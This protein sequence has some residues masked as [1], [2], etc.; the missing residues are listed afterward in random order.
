MFELNEKQ[1]VVIIRAGEK[2]LAARNFGI[3]LKDS[4]ITASRF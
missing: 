2:V 4:A 3:K 1:R